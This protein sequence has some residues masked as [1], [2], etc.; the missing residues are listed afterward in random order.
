MAEWL[1]KFSEDMEDIAKL[2]DQNE[3]PFSVC[4]CRF[5]IVIYMSVV[6]LKLLKRVEQVK[7]RA[8]KSPNQLRKSDPQVQQHIGMVRFYL[9]LSHIERRR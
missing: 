6:E 1:Q 9:R 5:V 7:Q 2:R 4:G 8:Q 3:G